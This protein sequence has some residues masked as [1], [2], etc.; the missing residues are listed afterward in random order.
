MTDFWASAPSR[1]SEPFSAKYDGYCHY[2]ECDKRNE[3]EQGD[4][5]EFFD[6]NLMHMRCARAAERAESA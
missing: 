4:C 3:V 1:H 6:G 5:C 2:L